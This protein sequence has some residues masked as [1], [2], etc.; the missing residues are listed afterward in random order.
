M[1]QIEQFEGRWVQERVRNKNT[2]WEKGKYELISYTYECIESQGKYR[3]K[4]KQQHIEKCV[5]CVI[6]GSFLDR[7]FVGGYSINLL[8]VNREYCYMPEYFR[9]SAFSFI[10]FHPLFLFSVSV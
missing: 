5:L 6:E 8:D 7:I 2:M 3:W 10:S 9:F 1:T 4:K